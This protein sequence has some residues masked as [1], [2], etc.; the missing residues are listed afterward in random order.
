MTDTLEK[1][2]ERI[3]ASVKPLTGEA[4]AA[5][6]AKREASKR[7]Q[8]AILVQELRSK[9]N[10]PLRQVGNRANLRQEGQWLAQKEKVFEMIGSGFLTALIG[11]R[12]SG[13]TQIAVETMFEVTNRG[14][15]ARYMTATEFFLAIKATFSKDAIEN[16]EEVL[17]KFAKLRLLVIDEIAKR[18]ETEW[19]NRLLFELI[20]RRYRNMR[21]TLV[22]ANQ[23]HVEFVAAIGSSLADRMNESG[24]IINCAWESFRK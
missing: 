15:S 22:I 4:L 21:D 2:L 7:Q 14:Y 23:T 19:E 6:E 8:H 24:G 13:K 20:D 10:A 12:G 11:S 18:G 1:K 9:W 17:A 16:E 3:V 5:H